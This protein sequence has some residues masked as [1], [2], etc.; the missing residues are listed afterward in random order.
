MK[1]LGE[2]AVLFALMS[3][4]CGRG[5]TEATHATERHIAALKTLNSCDELRGEMRTAALSNMEMRLLENEQAALQRTSDVCLEYVYDNP[6]SAGGEDSGRSYSKTNNQVA[7]ADEADFVKNDDTYLYV[8]ADGSFQIIQAYPAD[9]ARRLSRFPIQ[10][11]PKRLYVH[12]KRAVIF[13][14]LEGPFLGNNCT[15]GYD[16]DFLGDGGKLKV[17]TLDLSNLAEPKLV[18]E[19]T[20][21][22]SYLNARR[23]GDVV[24]LAM[25]TATPDI[26]G[27]R[28]RP[29]K[30]PG[31][32]SGFA[33]AVQVRQAFAQL[34]EENR[35]IIAQAELNL[36]LPQLTDV[37]AG[38]TPAQLPDPFSECQ[39]FYASRQADG[40]DFVSL[41]SFDLTRADPLHAATILGRSGAVYATQDHLYLA[42][43]HAY[44]PGSSWFYEDTSQSD[45]TTLHRFELYPSPPRAEYSASGAVKGRLLN[46]FSMDEH[47]GVL[48]LATTTGHLPDLKTHSTLL[49][50]VP[51]AGKLRVMGILDQLAPSEDIRSARFQ[52]DRGYVVTFKK[53]DPLFVF[54]LSNPQNPAVLGEL[55]IPGFSTYLHPLDT[56]HLMSIGFDAED[57]GSFAYFTGLQLQM[58]NVTQPSQPLLAF[59]EVIGTRGSASEAATDHLAFNYFPEKKLL[60]VPLTVCDS[61]SGIWSATPSFSG[62]FLYEVSTSSGFVRR[63]QLAHPTAASTLSCSGWWTQAS[64]AVR[65]TVFI[66]DA[67]YA[68]SDDFV[69]V[70][71][72]AAPGTELVRIHLRTR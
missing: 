40:D 32:E 62:L 13:S 8:L 58:F 71:R 55:K 59:K 25:V 38:E 2:V 57:Q 52:G 68:I 29:E 69:Q 54:D 63:G 46:Q 28:F 44:Q 10:G 34:R 45:A 39:N 6:A 22:G 64:S 41:V 47:Q 9:E 72:T 23:M 19:T 65:R 7:E 56:G 3:S 49:T 11:E 21:S 14:K 30:L 66:D 5:G 16:C 33:G 4:A 37:V 43:R 26:P 36:L 27:V 12:Q 1:R 15:Y 31:C 50:V 53:T 18:R 35:R 61:T 51:E 67:L 70:A 24:H 60:S 20:F 17:T 48:R 42:A